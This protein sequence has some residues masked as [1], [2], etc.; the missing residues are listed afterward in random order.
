M[1]GTWQLWAVFA[2]VFA[3]LT[4]VLSR[5]GVQQV[6]TDLAMWIRTLVV[7]VTMGGL[8]WATSKLGALASVSRNALFWLVLAGL[9]TGASWFCY[10]HALKL[11]RVAQ[12]AAVDKFSVVLVAVFGVVFLGEK[13][14]VLNWLG[15][16][17]V[18][19]GILLLAL[20]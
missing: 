3:A 10:F 8:L 18:A 4:A 17:L 19:A 13:L 20:K 16:V 12:V 1:Q 11:G 6:D 2:A 7:A 9:A 14:S 5:V 15:V